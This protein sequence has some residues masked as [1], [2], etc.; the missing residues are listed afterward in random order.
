M[1]YI[2]KKMRIICK[3]YISSSVHI[4]IHNNNL[5][6]FDYR[7]IV[8]RNVHPTVNGTL[9]YQYHHLQISNSNLFALSIY[10]QR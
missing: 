3:C 2:R 10:V 6:R 5:N 4:Y 7:F 9:I 1:T 8:F